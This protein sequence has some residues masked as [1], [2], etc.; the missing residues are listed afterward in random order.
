MPPPATEQAFTVEARTAIDLEIEVPVPPVG[1]DALFSVS[2]DGEPGDVVTLDEPSN[3]TFQM[4]GDC[5]DGCII[6]STVKVQN[7]DSEKPWSGR[8]VLRLEA[9][10]AED[11][12]DD[13]AF[14]RTIQNEVISNCT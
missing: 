13:I 6:R 12:V 4:L 1:D 14:D 11:Y 9:P 2:V 5:Y 7:C 10:S 8:V 3:G